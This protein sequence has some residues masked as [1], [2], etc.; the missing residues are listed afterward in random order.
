MFII[1]NIKEIIINKHSNHKS[2]VIKITNVLLLLHNYST[3][4]LISL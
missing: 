2:N 4:A 1:K 3:G